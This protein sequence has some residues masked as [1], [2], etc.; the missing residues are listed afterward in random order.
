RAAIVLGSPAAVNS[1]AELY[2]R[3]GRISD[4]AQIYRDAIDQ[5][6]LWAIPDLAMLTE[7]MGDEEETE[8]LAQRVLDLIAPVRARSSSWRSISPPTSIEAWLSDEVRREFGLL[9]PVR[10]TSSPRRTMSLPVGIWLRP[11]MRPLTHAFVVDIALKRSASGNEQSAERLFLKL[12]DA[13]YDPARAAL[14]AIRERAGD[15]QGAE[16]LAADLLADNTFEPAATMI[17]EMAKARRIAGSVAGA[18]R[19]YELCAASGEADA[20]AEL[21]SMRML[22]GDQTATR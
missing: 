8:R 20:V 3:C 9:A 18:A 7:E 13:G 15:E 6:Q 14:I 12:A 22:V 21:A 2:R 11:W 17:M 10:V 19:L 16:K 1:L 5:G 4:A